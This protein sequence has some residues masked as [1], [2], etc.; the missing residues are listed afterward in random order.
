MTAIDTQHMLGS[1]F[2]QE[3]CHGLLIF[4]PMALMFPVCASQTDSFYKLRIKVF[5]TTMDCQIGKQRHDGHRQT[6]LRF[7]I[8]FS[9]LATNKVCDL[10]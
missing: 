4:S 7:M 3:T 8:A 10:H 6:P 9:S 5:I 1:A 2:V